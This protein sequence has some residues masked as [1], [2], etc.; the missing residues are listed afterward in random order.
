MS[1]QLNDLVCSTQFKWNQAINFSAKTNDRMNER[2]CMNISG[3]RSRARATG[4]HFGQ[5]IVVYNQIA[6]HTFNYTY[7]FLSLPARDSNSRADNAW[8]ANVDTRYPYSMTHDKP[9]S[10]NS[11]AHIRSGMTS[12]TFESAS[13]HCRSDFA[14][15]IVHSSPKFTPLF[16][17]PRSESA[18]ALSNE[19]KRLC[20]FANILNPNNVCHFIF[21]DIEFIFYWTQHFELIFLEKLKTNVKC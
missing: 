10:Q 3:I 5:W 13:Y 6:C 1:R 19:T 14:L 4:C 7:A 18:H 20:H 16:I 15:L 2:N 9:L 8:N 12:G 17:L 11:H 21:I